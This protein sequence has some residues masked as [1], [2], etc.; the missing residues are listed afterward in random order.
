MASK[1]L[2]DKNHP[3]TP[4]V[5]QTVKGI[6]YLFAGILASTSVSLSPM[7]I[8]IDSEISMGAG[9]G[10]SAS[11]SVACKFLSG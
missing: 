10:S 2:N 9:T 11:F 1:A 7:C 5:L 3:P 8:T 6:L 4:E